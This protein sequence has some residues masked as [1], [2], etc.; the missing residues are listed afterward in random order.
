MQKSSKSWWKLCK[1]W[2]TGKANH[3]T[4]PPIINNDGILVKDEDKA[5]AFNEYFT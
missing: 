2:Y 4:I 5:D 3:H 1:F